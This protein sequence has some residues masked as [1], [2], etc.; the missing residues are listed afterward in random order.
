ML[1]FVL[2]LTR[3]QT[4]QKVKPATKYLTIRYLDTMSFK[5]VRNPLL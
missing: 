4:N 3:D 5:S 2:G 1:E